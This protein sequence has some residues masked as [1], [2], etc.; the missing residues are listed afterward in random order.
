MG[1]PRE[2]EEGGDS[3]SSPLIF[4]HPSFPFLNSFNPFLCCTH[5]HSVS[6]KSSSSSSSTSSDTVYFSWTTDTARKTKKGKGKRKGKME[7]VKEYGIQWFFKFENLEGNN[8]DLLM[9]VWWTSSWANGREAFGSLRELLL[10]P[11]GPSVTNPGLAFDDPC[12]SNNWI[13]LGLG[14]VFPVPNWPTLVHTYNLIYV[15]QA[16]IPVCTPP[17]PSERAVLHTPIGENQSAPSKNID[18]EIS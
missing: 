1:W 2:T 11:V 3:L 14:K 16:V 18:T 13:S 8:A 9:A 5:S 12:C 4:N 6:R 7:R 15:K 17:L 10:F